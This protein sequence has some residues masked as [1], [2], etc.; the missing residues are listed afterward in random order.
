[1]ALKEPS[2]RNAQIE[3]S[4]VA[5]TLANWNGASYIGRC[6][7]SILA[8]TVVPSEIVV[9]DN[10]S[11][12]GSL[13]LIQ[14]EFP[15]V[16]TVPLHENEGVS[17]AWN[18][19]IN[20]TNSPFVLILNADVF[21]DRDFL[22]LAG[23]AMEDRE[24]IGWLAPRVYRADTTEIENVGMFLQRRLRPVNSRSETNREIVFTGSGAAIFCRRR[25]LDDV[26][27]KGEVF[28]ESFFANMEDLD[29]AWRAH[30][31]GWSCMYEPRLVAHHVGSASQGGKVRVVEKPSFFQRHIWKNRW[32]L[33][34]KNAT[35]RLMVSLVPTLFAMEVVT[36][37]YLL[38]RMP[39]RIATFAAAHLDFFRLFRSAIEKRRIIQRNRKAGSSRVLAFL[40]GF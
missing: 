15:D 18:L 4:A 19:G 39:H 40:R 11:V 25:M 28:D 5:V 30:W 31:R 3:K 24:E 29:L 6:L 32:L 35:P 36:L 33:V 22:C 34:T 23:E 16:S 12:D 8:Q 38:V 37:L 27:V 10:G 14:A 20:S 1:M 13:E 17:R 7:E 21:L 9:V 2:S 26:S